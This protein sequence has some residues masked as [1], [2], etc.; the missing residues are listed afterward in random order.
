MSHAVAQV[1]GGVGLA[2]D[3]ASL[4]SRAFWLVPVR[5]LRT[6]LHL[7]P[8]IFGTF[9]EALAARA[10]VDPAPPIAEHPMLALR[11]DDVVEVEGAGS[12][13]LAWIHANGDVR[14]RLAAAPEHAEYYPISALRRAVE[15]PRRAA[16]VFEDLQ[17]GQAHRMMRALDVELGGPRE[18]PLAL[19][20]RRGRDD[21]L[22][23]VIAC[24]RPSRRQ[25]D[26]G[27]TLEIRGVATAGTEP[28]SAEKLLAR[29]GRRAA[30]QG[31]RRLVV[32]GSVARQLGPALDSAG[33]DRLAGA[34]GAAGWW[35]KVLR[36]SELG[37]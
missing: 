19:Q 17:P 9:R 10:A 15:K 2:V 14:V 28:R 37:A 1:R 7:P 22:L 24:A 36:V 4:N 30:E 33:W 3:I 27:L 12:G 29:A 13:T 35:V 21:A 6:A 5:V 23:G 8:T 32:L 18:S 11:R 31:Y 20:M 16:F 34:A 25:I 26:D